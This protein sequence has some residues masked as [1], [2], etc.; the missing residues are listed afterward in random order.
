MK[1]WAVQGEFR[2]RGL[3][4][5]FLSLVPFG[6]IS[7]NLGFFVLKRFLRCVCV[8]FLVSVHISFEGNRLGMGWLRSQAWRWAGSMSSQSRGSSISEPDDSESE[9]SSVEER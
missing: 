8:K 2:T 4:D 5:C 1:V 6:L 3:G 7:N 9:Y